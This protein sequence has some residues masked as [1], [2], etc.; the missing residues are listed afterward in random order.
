MLPSI[1][2]MFV[3][4]W[5]QPCPDR[6]GVWRCLRSI[7]YQGRSSLRR[8]TIRVTAPILPSSSWLPSLNRPRFPRSMVSVEEEA[9]VVVVVEWVGEVAMV[10]RE[11]G[12]EVAMVEEGPPGA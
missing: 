3:A 12:R 4:W 11:V 8:F 9:E 2:L 6:I 1:P 7:S 5:F 10:G